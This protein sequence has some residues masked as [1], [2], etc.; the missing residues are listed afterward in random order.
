MIFSPLVVVSVLSMFF[1]TRAARIHARRDG[2]TF[3]CPK[4]DL[5]GNALHSSWIDDAVVSCSYTEEPSNLCTYDLVSLILFSLH[6][7]ELTLRFR[8]VGN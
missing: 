6:K 5:D 1:S 3:V 7:L 2:C 8:P 4:N